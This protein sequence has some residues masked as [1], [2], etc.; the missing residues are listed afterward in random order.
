MVVGIGGDH[1][2]PPRPLDASTFLLPGEE[3]V[4]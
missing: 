4:S 1:G 2:R 3:R